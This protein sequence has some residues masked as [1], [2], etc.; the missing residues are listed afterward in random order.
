MAEQEPASQEMS[1]LWLETVEQTHLSA[2][3]QALNFPALRAKKD[4]LY[5][6]MKAEEQEREQMRAFLQDMITYNY[7]SHGACIAC[8]FCGETFPCEDSSEQAR[9]LALQQ[10]VHNEA[11]PII[12]ARTLLA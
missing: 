3:Q 1:W 4:A 12:E 10:V 11:C 7:V 8:L 5:A 2:M 6:R 9:E